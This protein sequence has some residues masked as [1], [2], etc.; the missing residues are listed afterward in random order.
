MNRAGRSGPRATRA[1]PVRVAQS[2]IRSGRSSIGLGQQVGQHQAAFGVGVADLDRE[3]LAGREH[4]AG[5]EAAAA[6]AVLD[7]ADQ[8]AQAHRQAKRH[9]R[10]GEAEGH[11]RAAHVL[12]HQP[13]VG[14]RLEVEP[15]G[16]EA[17]PLADQGQLAVAGIA[18]AQIDQPGGALAALADGVDRRIVGAKQRLARDDLDLGA[19]PAGDLAGAL[20]QLGRAEIGGGG[21]DQ[22][23]GQ[24]HRLGHHRGA[25]DRA[26]RGHDQTGPL[27]L[28][29]AV[30]VE[31]IGGQGPAE[32]GDRRVF[33]VRQPPVAARQAGGQSGEVPGLGW[34]AQDHH[35]PGRAAIGSRQ[36]GALAGLG[37]EADALQPAPLAVRSGRPPA[38]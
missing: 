20:G 24:L 26:V 1:A 12:L 16:V 19:E 4:V 33:G 36:Q 29:L 31:P 18:P 2:R 32:G 17:D 38:S 14:R 28:V 7:R 15:A 3:A 21:V 35:R 13:H 8:Q 11:R 5:A 25:G 10:L 30:A 34:R 22:V 27:G 37:D 6:D 9:D 23:A